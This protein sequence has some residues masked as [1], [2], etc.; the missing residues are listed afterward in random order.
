VSEREAWVGFAAFLQKHLGNKWQGHIVAQFAE[1]DY[2]FLAA[3]ANRCGDAA[4]LPVGKRCEWLC[5]KNLFRLLSG[6]G[7]V[8]PSGCGF[9]DILRWYGFW[10]DGKAH[11]A[12]VD[13]RAGVQVFRREISDLK[14]YYE[15]E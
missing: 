2:G 3:L 9:E 6:L 1:F 11:T 15:G 4:L 13:A 12:L 5:T 14:R 8:T 10:Y 7:I